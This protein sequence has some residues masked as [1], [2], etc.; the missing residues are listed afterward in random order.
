LINNDTGIGPK[1][2]EQWNSIYEVPNRK[3]SSIDLGNS[4][5]KC[6]KLE[7]ISENE[8][9]VLFD[10]IRELMRNGFS[11]ADSTKILANLPDDSKMIQGNFKTSEIKEVSL[12]QKIIPFLQELHMESFASENA[13]G[14]YDFVFRLIFQIEKRLIERQK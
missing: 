7:L 10:H 12:N 14:Y 8:K 4:I 2:I 5:E 1:P 13:K 9:I 11:H 3:Y 6:K